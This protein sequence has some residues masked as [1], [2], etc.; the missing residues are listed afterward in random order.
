MAAI[1]LTEVSITEFL[2]TFPLDFFLGKNDRCFLPFYP[3]RMLLLLLS[4]F[5]RVRLL[6]T[7]WTAAYQA[8][9]SMGFARQ[10]YATREAHKQ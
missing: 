5:S 8:P 9:L 4:R 7:P 6:L 2:Y 3:K 1:C 10:E